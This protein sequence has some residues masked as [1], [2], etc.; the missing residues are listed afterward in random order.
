MRARRRI[1][2]P[3]EKVTLTEWLA[4]LGLKVGSEVAVVP[5]GRGLY[6]APLG[7]VRQRRQGRQPTTDELLR[8]AIRGLTA[9]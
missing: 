5:I 1:I 7:K 8:H 9:G 2:D 3:D 6:I 4:P